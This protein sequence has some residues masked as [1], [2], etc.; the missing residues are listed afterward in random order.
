[1]RDNELEVAAVSCGGPTA[2]R[3]RVA[4]RDRDSEAQKVVFRSIGRG[5]FALGRL[6]R[7]RVVGAVVELPDT[8][9]VETLLFHFQIGAQ[10]QFRRQFLNGEA[11]RLRGGRKSLVTDR[12][13]RLAAAARK[14]F[15]RGA[16]VDHRQTPERLIWPLRG[17]KSSTQPSPHTS[18]TKHGP[19]RWRRAESDKSRKP[20]R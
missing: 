14:K 8:V 11:D 19:A 1:M 13:A 3:I 2:T 6:A 15:G 12:T 20:N 4:A 5:D 16:V 9:A 17:R 18:P 7:Q 10:K